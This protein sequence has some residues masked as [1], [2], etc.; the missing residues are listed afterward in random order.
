MA[1]R[2]QNTAQL[3]KKVPKSW[4]A[5]FNSAFPS[6]DISVISA[7]ISGISGIY[8][9]PPSTGYSTPLI[10]QAPRGETAWAR[11]KPWAQRGSCIGASKP[12]TVVRNCS[13]PPP[14]EADA[15][16]VPSA[17]R[18]PIPSRRP[19]FST[20][21]IMDSAF[22][23]DKSSP[24]ASAAEISPFSWHS[25]A[26]ATAEAQ[27]MVSSPRRLQRSLAFPM[28]SRS[29]F[30]QREPKPATVSYSGPGPEYE[31]VAG[32]GSLCLNTDLEAIGKANDL[33]NR[34]G[35]DTITCAS[36]VA[37]AL[38]CHENGLISAAEADGL[39][40]SWGNAES[41]IRLVEKI[42]RREGIGDLLAEG[43]E[44][45]SASLGG[46]SEQFLTTVKGLEA[47]MHDPRWAHGF[48]LAY[49][50]SPRG[51]CHMSGVEYPVEG[52]GMYIPEI[53]EMAAEITE[54]SSEGK[55]ELNV[56]AQDFGTFFSSCAVFCN[57]GAMVLN[58]TQ[59]VEMVNHATGFDYTLEEVVGIGRRVWYLKRGLSNLFGARTE[60]DCLP[61]RLRTVLDE[62][63]TEGSSPNMEL[64]L[65]EFY[66]LRRLQPD[67]LPERSVLEEMGM[68]T[69]TD[70]LC[71]Q[72]DS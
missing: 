59:A 61:I 7:A 17:R 27:V 47:P 53:P 44:R 20:S 67:G 10:W 37:F 70:A 30:R 15:R 16:S 64:M 68:H 14:R 2:L 12:F 38:E 43:T 26:K 49:A 1:P 60:H 41:M 52:G 42:G 6:L 18:S 19:I 32:F 46:G 58:A 28:A 31:T 57:L 23:H 34:L 9:P 55:A 50:I 63:P 33:C 72:P 66:R 21:R 25:K 3:E 11:P 29:V 22:P 45:A 39:D 8:M 36:A 51:A 54:M 40:L 48:G 71:A 56:A 5:T 62:G 24:S 35:L 4:A 69:L 13:D 65:Q